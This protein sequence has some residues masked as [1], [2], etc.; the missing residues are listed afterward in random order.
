M[1]EEFNIEGFSLGSLHLSTCSSEVHERE[2]NMKL[3][4]SANE[5]QILPNLEGLYVSGTTGI[6]TAPPLKSSAGS[7]DRERENTCPPAVWWGRI[8][9]LNGLMSLCSAADCVL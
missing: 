8:W 4:N 6:Q 7:T 1:S 3:F 9:Q 5:K 2:E